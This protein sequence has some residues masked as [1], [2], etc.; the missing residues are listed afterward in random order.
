MLGHRIRWRNV[1]FQAA[2]VLGALLTVA[3]VLTTL[4]VA[5]C[6]PRY[7]AAAELAPSAETPL[8][9]AT[10]VDGALELA[11]LDAQAPLE[12]PGSGLPLWPLGAL[13]IPLL[14]GM[15]ALAKDRNTPARDGR[16]LSYLLGAGKKVFAGSIVV[17]T[18][19]YA[20]A[21]TAAASLKAVGRANES[22]DNTGG[23]AGAKSVL[24]ERGVF[25]FANDGTI[26]QADVG[27][28]CYIVDDQT[29]ARAAGADPVKSAAGTIRGLEAG[30]VW[31][32]I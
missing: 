32:E 14:G 26:T 20:E 5:S 6:Q 19:G 29:V 24:V 23:A 28:T 1:T 25:L 18:G 17:L 27:G 9:V 3:L 21:G 15:T 10:P 11:A 22:V 8:D 30:G 12:E 2:S 13:G 16:V 7:A 4:V 31:V